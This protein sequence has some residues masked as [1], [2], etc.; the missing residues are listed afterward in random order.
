MTI[1]SDVISFYV[2]GV[3]IGEDSLTGDNSI[4]NLSN[5]F[6]WIGKGGYTGDASW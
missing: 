1:N 6:V 5:D 3:F 4:A 2:D